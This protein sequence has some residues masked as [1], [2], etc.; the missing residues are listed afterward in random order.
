M[1]GTKLGGMKAAETNKAK[2]GADFYQRIGRRGGQSGVTGGFYN[3]PKLAKM[4]GK[5][6]G[7]ISKRGAKS[8]IKTVVE[9]LN[10]QI[11]QEVVNGSSLQAIAK[12]YK[13][14]YGV[15]CKWA[16][17]NIEIKEWKKK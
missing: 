4:A 8:Y 10:I 7:T 11:I 13:L 1:S 3:N 2:H 5:K 15:L 12:K 9:P 14:S 17:E 6:G 16:K